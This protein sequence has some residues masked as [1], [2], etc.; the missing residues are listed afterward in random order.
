MVPDVRAQLRKAVAPPPGPPGRHLVSGRALREESRGSSSICGVP[1]T[2]TATSSTFSCSR[3][4]IG[5]RPHGFFRKLLKRQGR[6]PPP[7]DHR[8]TAQLLGGAPYRDA[9]RDPQYPAV[10]KQFAREVS[11]QSTRQRERQMRRFRSA[12][13]LQR[14]ASVHGVVQN[15]FRVGR[16]LLRAAHH[17][18]LR[19]VRSVSGM[20]LRVPA[21]RD[22]G[23]QRPG[24]KTRARRQL[25]NAGQT[26]ACTTLEDT[27][28]DSPHLAG[29]HLFPI[30]SLDGV[31]VPIVAS[32][33]EVA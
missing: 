24:R 5:G 4:A 16:H 13:H 12:A 27:M 21:D 8:Q 28:P 25:D 3:G 2:R 20:R 14:F 33:R 29:I 9:V 7:A 22:S 23:A 30:K 32:D 26:A 6:E 17:R 15:L 10:R 1:W 11:H 19:A 31:T 18:L